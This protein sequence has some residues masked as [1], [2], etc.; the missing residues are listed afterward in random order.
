[1]TK[2]NAVIVAGSEN[3]A[4]FRN[5]T[6]WEMSRSVND[7]RGEIHHVCRRTGT[8]EPHNRGSRTP[9][10]VLGM[11]S[12]AVF[13]ALSGCR[14]SARQIA[15]DLS[16]S[17]LFVETFD[18]EGKPLSQGTAFFITPETAL[19]NMHVMKWAK[20]LKLSSP[21]RGVSFDVAAV[22]G[23]N[24]E[25]DL[26]VLRVTS[27][28]GRPLRFASKGSVAV[29]D[30]VYVA[31]NPKGLTG[32]VSTGIVSSVREEAGLVQIDAPIS[33]GS[34]G[35]PVVNDRGEVIGVATLSLVAG[36]NLNFA[37]ETLGGPTVRTGN[38]T[39]FDVGKASLS[40]TETAFLKG[41][42][43]RVVERTFAATTRYRLKPIR[44]PYS[45]IDTTY[46]ERGMWTQ[47]KDPNW[48]YNAEGPELK[49]RMR[50]FIDARIP[51]AETQDGKVTKYDYDRGL[52]ALASSRHFGEIRNSGGS[53][54]RFDAFGQLVWFEMPNGGGV[55][56]FDAEGKETTFS[57]TANGVA[58]ERISYT[59]LFDKSG[60][61]TVMR[62][63]FGDVVGQRDI[64]Y[65]ENAEGSGG[66]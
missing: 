10:R 3:E 51:S 9:L 36:Q 8:R 58:T 54:T 48:Q 61:W 17:T 31:G 37:V 2:E 41:P 55:A 49:L 6:F 57:P 13:V 11:A 23:V 18:A 38:W 28:E 40:D 20:T 35:G 39:A 14:P 45:I 46:N 16:K 43:R 4:G 7:G 12:M 44:K 42:V 47:K 50:D 15:E 21:A 27:K 5:V 22:V 65:Y 60:N 64:D 30:K 29:G 32:T 33:P 66:R 53:R 63:D 52:K 34:S 62:D 1:M 56:E 26:C 19:T 25:R 24:F 59:Y